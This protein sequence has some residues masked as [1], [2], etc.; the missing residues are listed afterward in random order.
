M[1]RVR[2]GVRVRGAIRVGVR[3]RVR[4]TPFRMLR[5]LFLSSADVMS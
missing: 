1:V 2:V 3:V 5:W 4:V